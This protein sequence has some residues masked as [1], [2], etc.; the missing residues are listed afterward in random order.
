M[1]RIALPA[2]PMVLLIAACPEEEAPAEKAVVAA[3][4]KVEAATKEEAPAPEGTEPRYTYQPIGKRDPFRSFLTLGGPTAAQIDGPLGPLQEHE[5][6]Q[7]KLRGI[8]WNVDAPR[9][10][11]E[12]PDG[13]GHVVEIG[14]VIGKNWGKITQIKPESL[15]IT[16]EYRDP[17]ENELIVHEVTM[18]LPVVDG[19]DEKKK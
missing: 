5:I 17:I 9:G 15:I 4:K 19:E 10:L 7:Y 14:T 18:R 1:K 13:T 12:A 8:V 2:V 11:V 3:A 16:E 6:D